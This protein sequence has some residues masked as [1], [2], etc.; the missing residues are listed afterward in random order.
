MLRCE[1]CKQEYERGQ[2]WIGF[3]Q[4]YPEV[5][6]IPVAPVVLFYCRDCA[7]ARFINRAETNGKPTSGFGNRKL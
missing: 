2:G 4:E 5:S 3:V 1:D 6:A 7:T